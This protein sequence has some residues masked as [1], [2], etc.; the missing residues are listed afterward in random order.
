MVEYCPVSTKPLVQSAAPYKLGMVTLGFSHTQQ[1]QRKKREE[2]G[3]KRG[4]AEAGDSQI[5]GLPGLLSSRAV[6][7]TY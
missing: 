2:G 3:G 7:A 6:R 5:Q 4:K 1:V